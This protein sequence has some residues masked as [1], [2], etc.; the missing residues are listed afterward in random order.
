M[1]THGNQCLD[2]THGMNLLLLKKHSCMNLISM[3]L[4]KLFML[5][6]LHTLE[7]IQTKLLTAGGGNGVKLLMD[8]GLMHL[9]VP[10]TTR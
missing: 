1:V 6:Q 9:G 3:Q 5:Q 10:I 8:L 2:L 7:V 4:E